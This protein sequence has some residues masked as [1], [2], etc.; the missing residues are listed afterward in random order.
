[1]FRAVT[2]RGKVVF[3]F[4]ANYYDIL[5]VGKSSSEKEIKQAFRNLA[6]KYHPDVNPDDK[7]AEDKFKKINEAYEVLSNPDSKK[8]Y[9]MYGDNWQNLGNVN[10]GTD[11]GNW[12]PF[13]RTGREGNTENWS[14]NFGDF[15]DL[16]SGNRSAQRRKRYTPKPIKIEISLKE[17]FSGTAR[18]VSINSSAGGSR[19]I[20]VQ[21][22][23]GVDTNSKIKL[24]P[25]GMREVILSIKV[26][27]N[28]KFQRNKNDL[29]AEVDVDFDDLILGCEIEVETIT[30]KIALALPVNSQNKQKI[31]ISGQGM[32]LLDGDGKRG[33]FFVIVNAVIPDFLSEKQ[34]Q[35]IL[36]YSNLKSND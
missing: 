5:G 28:I 15:E 8:K 22:P 7:Q 19:K 24:N 33:D 29:Y 34:K 2:A 25:K 23:P 1:M 32:P 12:W 10:H 9:D 17:A 36:S 26:T 14:T 35:H 16:F 11:F 31:K 13:G 6:R 18:Q 30:G 20:E 21:I 27:Q 3:K 4:M